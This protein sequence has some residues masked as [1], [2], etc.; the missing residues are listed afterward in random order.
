MLDKFCRP[1]TILA[2]NTSSLSVT[3]I[4]SI[5]YRAEKCVGMRFFN[6]V[7]QMKLLE[8]VRAPETD[9]DTLAA[10]VEVAKRMG[11]EVV[12]LKESVPPAC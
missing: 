1:A 2:S 7:H 10:V 9:D 8:I 4:A 11:K 3:E 5:T 12:V 6:P